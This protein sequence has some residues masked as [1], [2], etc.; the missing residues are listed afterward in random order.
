MIT[1]LELRAAI[2]SKFA[3]PGGYPM[4]GVTNDGGCLCM[5]CMRKEYKAIAYA[6]RNND[7]GG[8][9]VEGVDVNWENPELYCDH[10]DKRIESAYAEDDA[11]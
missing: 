7:S 5:D 11:E 3:W 8:W 4:F 9:L 6:R 10:C 1:S 2:R